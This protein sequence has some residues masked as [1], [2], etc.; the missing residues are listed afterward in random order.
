M[1]VLLVEHLRQN[2]LISDYQAGFTQG[3]RI[4]ENLYILSHS[5]DG[6][7][8]DS[9]ELVLVAIDF[10]KA[11]DSVD[12][13]ALIRTLKKYRCDSQIIDIVVGVYS[14]D[15]TKICRNGKEIGEIEITSGIRQGCTGSPQLFI[16]VVQHIIEGI[17]QTGLGYR[18]GDFYI[19]VLFYADD[20]LL[21]AGNCAEAVEM[22]GVMERLAHECGMSMNRDKS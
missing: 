5:V 4:E 10:A 6:A 18:D 19:P 2:W 1:Q 3:R 20:G 9:R 17:I 13:G 7:F 22:V 21:L 14:G 12:R 15:K 16:M 8:R 11:F